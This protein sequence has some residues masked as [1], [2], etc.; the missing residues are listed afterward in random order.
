[1]RSDSMGRICMG[2][3]MLLL[4]ATG[5][6]NVDLTTASAGRLWVTLIM[7]RPIRTPITIETAVCQNSWPDGELFFNSETLIRKLSLEDLTPAQLAILEPRLNSPRILRRVC[8][9]DR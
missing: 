3:T 6:G 9:L 2:M 5:P 7:S 4:A 1:M 8:L